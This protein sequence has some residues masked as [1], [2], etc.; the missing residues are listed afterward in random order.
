M[1]AWKKVYSKTIVKFSKWLTVEK[2]IVRLPD[3]TEIP[4]WAWLEMP[5]Y[6]NV[7]VQTDNGEFLVFRQVKYAIQGVTFAP[8]GGYIEPD[9][10][11]LDAAQ[12]ELREETGYEAPDWVDLGTYVVDANRGAGVARLFLATGAHKVTE[13]RA[14]DLE[15]QEIVLMKRDEFV[16]AL[17]DGEFKA[18]SWTAA[19]ALAL[20]R[21]DGQA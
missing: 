2:H 6:I 14:D 8:V 4:D 18:L 11:A 1:R 15:E 13:P 10:D 5:A 16:K 9:E 7:V 19:I 12:R 21:L 17:H 3:G 20:L